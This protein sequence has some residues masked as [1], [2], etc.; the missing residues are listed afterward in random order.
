MLLAG[1]SNMVSKGRKLNEGDLNPQ[2]W[3]KA[4]AEKTGLGERRVKMVMD[5]LIEIGE[6]CLKRGDIIY[7]PGVFSVE[8]WIAPGFS[9][10]LLTSPKPGAE[11][12]I[13]NF[14]PGRQVKIFPSKRL[15]K[16]LRAST[17]PGA[18][19]TR[20]PVGN[21]KRREKMDQLKAEQEKQKQQEQ[22]GEE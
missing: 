22:G 6:E 9:A 5:A 7:W 2:R 16:R 8:T 13:Y 21:W 18:T 10:N 17:P 1:R 12:K 3:R 11:R 20:P 14:P 19:P 4:I 15:K